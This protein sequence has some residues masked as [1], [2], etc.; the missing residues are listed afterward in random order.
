[1]RKPISYLLLTMA[2]AL[3]LATGASARSSGPVV[4]DFPFSESEVAPAEV[5]PGE[6]ATGLSAEEQAQAMLCMTN[7]AR[8][9]DGMRPL[10]LSR[11]LGR[12]AEQKSADIVA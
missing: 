9:V 10:T 1:M 8:E 3:I 12:A 6:T 7:Y 5:C 4:R 2:G 11:Q